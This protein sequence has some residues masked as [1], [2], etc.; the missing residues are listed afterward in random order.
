MLELPSK[1]AGW[2]VS[3]VSGRIIS[4]FFVTHHS[5]PI[6]VEA[7]VTA[8]RLDGDSAALKASPPYVCESAAVNG[9][10]PNVLQIRWA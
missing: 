4:V 3:V 9:G 2:G 5:N 6:A 8:V 10:V 7:N 1:I